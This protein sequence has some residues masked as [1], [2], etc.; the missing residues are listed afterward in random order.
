MV[1]IRVQ[2]GEKFAALAK[3]IRTYAD[4]K[5]LQKQF[6]SGI[7]RAAKPLIKDV[8]STALTRLPKK[9]GLA[10]RVARSRISTIRRYTGDGA[11]V[12]IRGTSGYD[13]SSINRGRVRHLSFGHKPWVNQRV[14]PRFWD[15]PLEHGAP[16]VRKELLKVMRDVANKIARG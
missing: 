8:R 15:D 5:A 13:I 16:E 14:R 9:G 2:G 12:R 7:N 10:K 11:G 6:Y 1:F 4:R 3:R